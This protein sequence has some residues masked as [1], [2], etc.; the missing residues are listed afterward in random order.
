MA[1]AEGAARVIVAGTDGDTDLRL[2]R[3]EELGFEVCNVQKEDL[4]ERVMAATGGFG[5]DVVVEAAGSPAAIGAGIRALRRAES[6]VVSGI[7]GRDQINVPWDELVTKAA[8]VL[9]AYSSRPRNWE[10]GL[11]YLAEG[12]VVTEPLVTHRF[13]LEDWRD[14][15]DMMEHAACIRALFVLDEDIEGTA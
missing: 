14:A 12:K 13:R 8:L 10:T 5:A 3:A 6:M 4:V 15:F 11:R 2:P 9:F 1:R 7:T